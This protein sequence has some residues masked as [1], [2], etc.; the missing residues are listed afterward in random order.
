MELDNQQWL[1]FFGSNCNNKLSPKEGKIDE[2]KKMRMVE[3]KGN[4][5]A[6]AGMVLG[7]IAIVF[8]IISLLNVV[9]YVPS[10]LAAVFG[11][12][13]VIKK[14]GGK[15]VAALVLG[16]LSIVIAT[17]ANAAVFNAAKTAVYT[18]QEEQK[19]NTSK[20]TQDIYDSI[21][22]ADSKFS[23]DYSTME[24]SGGT[25]YSDIELKVGKP[26]S[27]TSLGVSGEESVTAS[28]TSLDFSGDGKSLSI[29]VSYDKGSGQITAKNKV[30]M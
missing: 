13:G 5:L 6:T 28:W 25:L 16:V 27:T 22:V 18:A 19:K 9:S 26:T 23:A 3:K 11:F 7:I 12:I 17:W 20:W 21:K 2:I 14:S 1:S 15:A 4:G 8:T 24:Y 30:E 29:T 10:A